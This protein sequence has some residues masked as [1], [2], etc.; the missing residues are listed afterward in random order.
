[1]APPSD[2]HE[3]GWRDF[4][5]HLQEKADEQAR[6]FQEQ[7]QVFQEQTQ[8]FQERVEKMDG[9][10]SA[11]KRQ[12][13]GRKSEKMPSPDRELQKGRSSRSN[14]DE[15]KKKRQAALDARRKLESEE[16]KLTVPETHSCPS[17]GTDREQ[18]K[19]CGKKESVEFSFVAAH[20]RRKVYV[21]ETVACTCGKHIITADAPA[22][23]GDKTSFSPSFIAY[24]I[25]AKCSDS[26]P[27]YR[28]EKGYRRTGI[29]IARST[30]V[31]LF[32]QAAIILSPLAQRVLTIISQG[33]VVLADE[34]TI[35]VQKRKKKAYIW[36]FIAGDLIGYRFSPSRS[37]QTP[38]DVLG[39][40]KGTLLVD[41][42]TGY[43]AVTTP[44]G[45]ERAGCLAHAR[46]KFFDALPT[47]PE[48]QEALDKILEV[49]RVERDAR[50]Q[51]V[52]G[53]GEHLAMRRARSVPIMNDL[54]RWLADQHKLH[55]PKSPLGKAIG[56]A[57]NNWKELSVFLRNADV[58]PDNNTSERALRVVALG[59]KNFLHVGHD[60]AG[61]N[62]ACLYTLTATCESVGV[63]P[64]EYLTDVLMR[65]ESH[66][67]SRIDELLPQNWTPP[68]S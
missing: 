29:P 38:V 20:F 39:Q 61:E 62:L 6:A 14:S 64:L 16:I 46:R 33:D 8:V 36:T 41:G 40:S 60:E 12:I 48:A 44:D 57:I 19:D 1:M 27:F 23:F 52:V 18:F 66:P 28:L 67:A 31:R 68:A 11:L 49:Y 51:D 34:T 63:N 30:M 45:R 9:E 65:T 3:C 10:L 58:P 35:R 56:Y 17:C 7:T 55:P 13:H 43:N 42:Y 4:A 25:T 59:R 53:T 32:H 26:I 47:A 2:D 21:R 37:G 54:G 15:A 22:R 50:E 5:L 24:L